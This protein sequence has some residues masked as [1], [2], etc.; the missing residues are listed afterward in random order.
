MCWYK[1]RVDPVDRVI[2][3]I[4]VPDIQHIIRSAE[5]MAYIR[6]MTYISYT[7]YTNYGMFIE[8][9]LYNLF[10]MCW[11]KYRVNPVDRV[12][13]AIYV[14]DIQHII[15]FAEVMAYIRVM[16]YIS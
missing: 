16:T 6:V 5:V 15:R 8:S 10:S 13:H 1:Y 4:Y 7:T 12:I 14:P 3:A 9:I 2:H 11:Y